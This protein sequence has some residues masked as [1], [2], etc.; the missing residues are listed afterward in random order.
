MLFSC[1]LYIFVWSYH[2]RRWCSALLERDDQPAWKSAALLIP[3]FNLILLID[4]GKL[5]ETVA[6]RSE[7][8]RTTLPLPLIGF[9][10]FFVAAL[11]RLPEP[12][13]LANLLSFIPI[14]VLQRVL[15]RAELA[16][17]G[18]E[19]A[20]TRFSF[21]EKTVIVLGAIFLFL[22]FFGI[23]HPTPAHTAG[24]H[25]LWFPYVVAAVCAATLVL[26]HG[27]SRRDLAAFSN[28]PVES[29]TT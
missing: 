14:A 23:T 28:I 6:A 13:F 20:P 5:I 17:T 27:A 3:F 4:L 19:A 10:M 8:S 22:A 11:S 25:A 9:S 26:I 12:Y 24:A 18:P 15:V 21:L 1:G 29:A 16:I 7:R 2:V